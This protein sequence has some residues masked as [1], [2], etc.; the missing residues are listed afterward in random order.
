MHALVHLFRST[1]T[2]A[3]RLCLA[4]VFIASPQCECSRLNF[5]DP[6][7]KA[8]YRP[9]D[10]TNGKTKKRK[11]E[12]V[13]LSPLFSL[14][15][16]PDVTWLTLLNCLWAA[17]GLQKSLYLL[18]NEVKF[19]WREETILREKSLKKRIVGKS[20]LSWKWETQVN[21]KGRF[22]VWSSSPRPKFQS[23]D[24]FLPGDLR[25]AKLGQSW[26]SLTFE[27]LAFWN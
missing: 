1:E 9:I 2:E 25:K 10:L 21:I 17:E 4:N 24:S 13:F 11:V 12:Y 15:F 18:E 26:I 6:W 27:P 19:L 5:K 22:P 7:V 8:S 20:M 14:Q 16:K 3:L 23:V